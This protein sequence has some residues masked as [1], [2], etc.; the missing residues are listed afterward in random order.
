MSSVFLL[1]KGRFQALL[2]GTCP[3]VNGQLNLPGDNGEV[4][5]A[6]RGKDEPRFR[7]LNVA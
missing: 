2:E 3:K 1:I 7:S 5:G 6:V 4:K